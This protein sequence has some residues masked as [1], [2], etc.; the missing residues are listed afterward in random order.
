MNNR[1]KNMRTLAME[2]FFNTELFCDYPIFY[3]FMQIHENEKD[4]AVSLSK[5]IHMYYLYFT[6]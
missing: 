5:E 6:L 1:D 3:K 2:K 4:Q